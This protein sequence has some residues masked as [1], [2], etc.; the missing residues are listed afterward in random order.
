V[1]TSLPAEAELEKE[2]HPD[3]ARAKGVTIGMKAADASR[4][5]LG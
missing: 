5:M 3:P 2:S 4:L 1:A